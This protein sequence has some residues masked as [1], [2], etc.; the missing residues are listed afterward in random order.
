MFLS[1]PSVC[2]FFHTPFLL[3]LS[4]RS[5]LH[6]TPL[7]SDMPNWSVIDNLNSRPH[8]R[9]QFILSPLSVVVV[10]LFSSPPP[11]FLLFLVQYR[12][13]FCNPAPTPPQSPKCL[14]SDTHIVTLEKMKSQNTLH[15]L[16]ALLVALSISLL[17]CKKSFLCPHFFPC[18][19]KAEIFSV[20]LC[21]WAFSGLSWTLLRANVQNGGQ[22]H[23]YSSEKSHWFSSCVVH[24]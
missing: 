17:V 6:T 10:V 3:R 16:H 23:K 15:K 2:L 1:L 7:S 19:I 20:T 12:T 11:Q 22:T 4:L 5:F 14:C 24:T 18:S 8:R 9:A 21:V 13:P